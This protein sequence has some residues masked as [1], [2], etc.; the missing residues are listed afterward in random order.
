MTKKKHVCQETPR[1]T[2]PHGGLHTCL[3]QPT[4][5]T[6]AGGSPPP[7]CDAENTSGRKNPRAWTHAGPPATSKPHSGPVSTSGSGPT[8]KQTLLREAQEESR[9]P[10]LSPGAPDRED[11]FPAHHLSLRPQGH[12]EMLVDTVRL[13]QNPDLEGHD[14]HPPQKPRKPISGDSRT[15]LGLGATA[16]VTTSVA[17]VRELCL[18]PRG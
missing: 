4:L 9:L 6:L 1:V 17:G 15:S 8:V 12:V 11:P 10:S 2:R 18:G 5:T 3:P 13:P 16:T 7:E 14:C